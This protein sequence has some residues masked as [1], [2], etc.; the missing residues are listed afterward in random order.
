MSSPSLLI[1]VFNIA[2]S[3]SNDSSLCLLALPKSFST[4]SLVRD[5][6]VSMPIIRTLSSDNTIPKPRSISTSTVSP[7]TTLNTLH[8]YSY[9]CYSFNVFRMNFSSYKLIIIF[10]AK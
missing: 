1:C 8:L 10:V 3:P 4:L 5:S 6:G 9:I 7:S 2:I